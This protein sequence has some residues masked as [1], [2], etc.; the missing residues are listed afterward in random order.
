MAKRKPESDCGEACHSLNARQ[1]AFHLLA[2]LVSVPGVE[3]HSIGD[4]YEMAGYSG[5]GTRKTR[6]SAAARLYGNVRIKAAIAQHRRQSSA[7]VQKTKNDAIRALEGIV[8]L[9]AKEAPTHGERLRAIE[10]LAKI[11]GWNAPDRLEITTPEKITE[12]GRRAQEGD[13]EAAAELRRIA[14]GGK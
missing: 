4:A 9:D 5:G 7:R 8:D 10:T 13:E 3:P 1:Y 6:D 12:L 11:H 2:L 14:G